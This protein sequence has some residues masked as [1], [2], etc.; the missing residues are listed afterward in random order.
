LLWTRSVSI[1]KSLRSSHWIAV[2]CILRY[3]HLAISHGLHLRSDSSS[4]LSAFSED[5]SNDNR[6][7]MRG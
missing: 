4:L 5:D 3:V 2:K 7:S 6:R 1:S